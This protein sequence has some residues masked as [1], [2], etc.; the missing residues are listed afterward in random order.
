MHSWYVSLKGNEIYKTYRE[1]YDLYTGCLP[2]YALTHSTPCLHI[3]A[4][5]EYILQVYISSLW[6]YVWKQEYA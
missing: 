4:Y 6:K 3:K 2:L 1:T 5:K